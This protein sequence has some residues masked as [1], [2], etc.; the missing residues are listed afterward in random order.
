MFIESHWIFDEYAKVFPRY[1]PS[2]FVQEQMLA[3]ITDRKV[4]AETCWTWAMNDYKPSS[5]GKMLDYYQQKLEK[6]PGRFGSRI[7]QNVEEQPEPNCKQCFDLKT[8]SRP[9]PGAQYEWELTEAPCPL[10]SE[11]TV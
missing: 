11:V 6:A 9:K 5:V 4:W 7:G 8:V 1:T 3:A 2:I 10:C